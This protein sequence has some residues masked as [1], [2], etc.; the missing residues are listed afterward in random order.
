[1]HTPPPSPG[2]SPLLPPPCSAWYHSLGLHPEQLRDC[3]SSMGKGNF[4]IHSHIHRN[5]S[6]SHSIASN[7]ACSPGSLLLAAV[8]LLLLLLQLTAPFASRYVEALSASCSFNNTTLGLCDTRTVGLESQTADVSSSSLI[9]FA[10]LYPALPC[11]T[12][13]CIIIT[14]TIPYSSDQAFCLHIRRVLADAESRLIAPFLSPC[15]RLLPST[16]FQGEGVA[17]SFFS[18]LTAQS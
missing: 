14:T 11:I 18:R 6:C 2:P 4:H 10:V 3:N 8:P 9:R 12:L 15:F 5:G 7:L 17:S 1:M 13:P 16:I